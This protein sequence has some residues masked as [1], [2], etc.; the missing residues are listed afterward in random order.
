MTHARTRARTTSARTS[1]RASASF[2]T[3]KFCALGAAALPSRERAT[4]ARNAPPK[5]ARLTRPSVAR[6]ASSAST[7]NKRARRVE[8]ASK[9]T[10]TTTSSEFERS[11]AGCAIWA[12][13]VRM[14]SGAARE[15]TSELSARN[16]VICAVLRSL[17]VRM[18]CERARDRAS[19]ALFGTTHKRAARA[20][21]RARIARPWQQR[22]RRRLQRQ[23]SSLLCLR[24]GRS[25]YCCCCRCRCSQRCACA[26]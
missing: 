21:A 4:R 3:H 6:G 2:A 19:L 14:R 25:C 26:L 1:E 7:T 17:V 11:R 9:P 16:S 13:D 12:A 8:R 5:L 10:T 24:S 22:R 18:H 23:Q 20:R 15:C